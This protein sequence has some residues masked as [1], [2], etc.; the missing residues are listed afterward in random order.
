MFVTRDVV[1]PVLSACGDDLELEL[2][3]REPKIGD[4]IKTGFQKVFGLLFGRE[5]A[6][7]AV[8]A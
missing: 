6:D 3:A 4:L 8:D 2:E 1:P 7:G 5:V